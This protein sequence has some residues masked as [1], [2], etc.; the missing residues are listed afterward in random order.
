MALKGKIIQKGK[1]KLSP[2][3]ILFFYNNQAVPGATKANITDQCVA[4]LLLDKDQLII[5][6][7]VCNEA[8]EGKSTYI[9]VK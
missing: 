5:R 3:N 4:I 2:G 9:R 7:V 1:W 8:I 6:E